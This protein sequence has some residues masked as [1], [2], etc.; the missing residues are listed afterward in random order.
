MGYFLGFIPEQKSNYQIR[1][2]VG[3]LGRVFDGQDVSVRW[4]KPE[5][6]H[7]TVLYLGEKLNFFKQFL[8]VYKLSKM[9]FPKF[10]VS[11][12]KANVGISRSYKELI[13][14]SVLDG[15]D[16]IRN[17]LYS[18]RGIIR[19]KESSLFIPH[20]TLGRINKDLSSEEYRNILVDVRNMNEVLNVK[21]IKFNPTQFH[22]LESMDDGSNRIVKTFN[23]S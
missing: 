12:E 3:E 10:Q 6:Y 18:L 8:L 19:T 9:S 1:K 20:V 5:N 2:A 11:F 7:I 16:E 14:L 21:D 22:L 17:M 13:Y 4:V 15:G 23:L